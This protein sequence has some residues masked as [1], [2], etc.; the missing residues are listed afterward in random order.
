[1]RQ[2]DP[3]SPMLF[4]VM[5]KVFSKMIKELKALVYF[6]VSGLMVDGVEGYVSHI[7]CLRMI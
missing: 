7:F 2:G 1:M 6:E 4:L 3:L 5:M